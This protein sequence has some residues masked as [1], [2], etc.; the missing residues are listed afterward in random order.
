MQKIIYRNRKNT[1]CTKWDG[2]IERF[3]ADGLMPLWV[4]D[5]DFESPQCVKDSLTESAGNGLYGYYKVPN[6]YFTAFLGWEK[7]HH[8]CSLQK[9]WLRFSPGVVPAINMLI[10]ILT[11]PN[12]G[13]GVMTPVYYPFL[14]AIRNN[15]RRLLDC[16]LKETNGFYEIDWERFE[17]LTTQ[18]NMKVF[19]LCSPHNPVGRVWSAQELQR[20]SDICGK[21]K[22]WLLADEIHHD[23]I[24]GERSHTEIMSLAIKNDRLVAMTSASKT[25]N[26]AGLKN[27][28]VV[29]PNESLRQEW[30]NFTQRLHISDGNMIGYIATAS[31][32]Q[33]GEEWLDGVIDIIRKNEI[34]LRE[35]LKR[36]LPLAV[37]SP[38]EG[39]YLSWI[40]LSKYLK[41]DQVQPAVQKK[42]GLAVDYGEWFGGIQYGGHIRINLATSNE[43][44]CRAVERLCGAVKNFSLKAE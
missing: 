4:A 31:A 7:A 32:Y 38:L 23:I 15:E 21:N 41:P 29:I 3:G 19:I 8:H 36:E 13:V 18:G 40:D 14:N 22:I 44:I 24:V 28:F 37:V 1:D 26:L 20:L 34:S 33:N 25:F 27:A 11:K 35:I 10:Q 39:T 2:V 43:N 30:D 16:P 12:E 42:A 17:S 9:D 6:S 5:M